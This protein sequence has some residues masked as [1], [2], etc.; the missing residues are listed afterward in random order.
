MGT[1]EDEDDE[2]KYFGED[3]EHGDESRAGYIVDDQTN[4][5]CVRKYNI[6]KSQKTGD[7]LQQEF[8]CNMN[9]RREGRGL[10][11]EQ[12]KREPKQEIRCGCK[13][14]FSVHVD[15]I[16]GRWYCTYFTDI[17]NHELFDDVEC[18]MQAPYRKMSL[19]DIAQ[20]N[21]YRDAG[22]GVP[23]IFRAIVNQCG[24][25]VKMSYSKK[26]MHNQISWQRWMLENDCDGNVYGDV[27]AFDVTYEENKYLLSIVVFSGVNNHNRTT[28]FAIAVVTNETEESYVWLLEQF[29][30]AMNGRELVAVITD[31]H[32]LNEEC[33]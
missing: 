23:H 2:L 29:L 15:I 17:H 20:M 6:I 10:T 5:F 11:L 9:G 26:S 12:W 21:S 13:A 4:G 16:S 27:L 8:V 19:S 14:N 31:G 32:P 7:I 18:G 24:G 28:V 22:T 1:M 33:N 3:V 25:V 30:A